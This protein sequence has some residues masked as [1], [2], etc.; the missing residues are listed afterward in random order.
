MT[1]STQLWYG[2]NVGFGIVKHYDIDLF[3]YENKIGDYGYVSL[4]GTKVS[5][6]RG[7]GAWNQ[8]RKIAESHLF[9]REQL[10][11]EGWVVA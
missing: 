3:T 10:E 8:I 1:N 6:I 2:E 5:E 7:E 9:K 4:D 11:Q